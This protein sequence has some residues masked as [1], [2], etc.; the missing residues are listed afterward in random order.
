MKCVIS[1]TMDYYLAIEK[2]DTLI[3]TTTQMNLENLMLRE[4]N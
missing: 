1:I 3:H 4:K 2:N